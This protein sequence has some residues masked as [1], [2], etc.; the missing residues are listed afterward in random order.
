MT[1]CDKLLVGN[2]KN[3]S[4]NPYEA[5]Q[6]EPSKFRIDRILMIAI[7]AIVGALL[8]FTVSTRVIARSGFQ[9]AHIADFFLIAIGGGVG[10]FAVLFW[11]HGRQQKHRLDLFDMLIEPSYDDERD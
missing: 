4:D 6:S 3:S 7:G 9:I 8:G 11:V 2:P 10:V 1:I 5:P